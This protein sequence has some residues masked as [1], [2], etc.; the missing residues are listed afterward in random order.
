[1]ETEYLENCRDNNLEGVTDC[2]S[3]GIDVNTKYSEKDGGDTGLMVACYWGHPA[4]V[5][6]L[7]QEPGLDINC[8]N[9]IGRTAAHKASFQVRVVHSH[10]S[11]SIRILCSDCLR[12]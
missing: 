5:T 12:S 2:L 4:I 6:R 10:W 8:Q 11:R 3:R 1:M 7:V 9:K